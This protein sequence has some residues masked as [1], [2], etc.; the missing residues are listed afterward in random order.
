MRVVGIIGID[1]EAETTCRSCTE[2]ASGG[3]VACFPFHS[4]GAERTSTSS[5]VNWFMSR[6]SDRKLHQVRAVESRRAI[7]GNLMLRPTAAMGSTWPRVSTPP[8]LNRLRRE[9]MVLTDAGNVI[10]YA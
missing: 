9:R 1:V 3:R 6:S 5:G 8:T 10:R 2:T 4:R 7:D